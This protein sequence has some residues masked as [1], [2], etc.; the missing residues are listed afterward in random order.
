LGDPIFGF[1]TILEGIK[2]H[3]VSCP[4]A[5]HMLDRFPYRMINAKWRNTG[6]KSSFQASLHISG[7]DRADIMTDISRI[8]AKDIGV[9]MRSIAINSEDKEFDGTLRIYVNDLEHLDFLVQK[10][11]NIKGVQSVTRSDS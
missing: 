5:K 8:I 9:Q 7:S 1:V 6:K 11:K 3:R 4:N 10:L 2:I